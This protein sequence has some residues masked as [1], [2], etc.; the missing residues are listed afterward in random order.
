M[1]HVRWDFKVGQGILNG[2]V[3]FN[4]FQNNLTSPQYHKILQDYTNQTL[5]NL[6]LQDVANIWF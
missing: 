4:S 2:H 3:L 5:E 1:H 6:S